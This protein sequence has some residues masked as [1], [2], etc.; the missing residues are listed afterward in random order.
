MEAWA[1]ARKAKEEENAEAVEDT[2][3]S[4]AKVQEEAKIKE[5]K[6]AR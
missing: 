1:Q 2:R 3:R 5:L 4:A 6:D